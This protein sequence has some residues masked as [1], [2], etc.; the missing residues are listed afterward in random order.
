MKLYDEKV[1]YERALAAPADNRWE[2]DVRNIVDSLD[3]MTSMRIG[4]TIDFFIKVKKNFK[5]LVIPMELY[6]EQMCYFRLLLES[7]NESHND[8]GLSSLHR[9]FYTAE[10]ADQ[11][12]RLLQAWKPATYDKRH[13]YTLVELVHETLKTLDTAKV[14]YQD[15]DNQG[16]SKYKKRGKKSDDLETILFQAM[17]F[18][19]N[20]YFKR[21]VTRQTISMYTQLMK[22]SASNPP[23]ITH[24]I[25]TF[26]SRV[27][28]FKL[29]QQFRAPMPPKVPKGVEL[30]QAERMALV[31]TA[32]SSEDQPDEQLSLGF[33]LFNY[34][35]LSV[36][37]DL[38]N[39]SSL[40][41]AKHMEP[42]LRLLKSTV[43]RFG[44][45][46]RKNHLLFVEALFPQPHPH[47]FCVRLDNVYEASMYASGSGSRHRDDRDDYEDD[48]SVDHRAAGGRISSNEYGDEDEFDENEVYGGTEAKGKAGK[49]NSRKERGGRGA[50]DKQSRA[51]K[52]AEKKRL[53]EEKKRGKSWSSEEDRVLREVYAQYLGASSIFEMIAG[54][55]EFS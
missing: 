54:S 33:L 21:L 52:K 5:D 53:K 48:V 36:I 13:M 32:M 18:D 44:N 20:D 14:R 50:D 8:L 4:D 17:R 30:S 39:D 31:A 51:A 7:A 47:E 11:L 15:S 3:R 16:S 41:Q 29:E 38:L 49:Q 1:R 28:A 23:H 46:A 19:V 43:R 25:Y 22:K 37:S 42:L 26:L 6:K 55:A 35:T 24:Y 9:T 40:A 10:R 2:P 34:S 27:S 45:A 12:P